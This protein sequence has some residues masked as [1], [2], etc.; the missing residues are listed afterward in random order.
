[1]AASRAIGRHRSLVGA[2]IDAAP[3]IRRA[4]ARSL[5][6]VREHIVSVLAF[7]SADY[8]TFRLNA[9][10]GWIVLG[11]SAVVFDWLARG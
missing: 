2:L 9:Y 3:G 11:V 7:T 4:A 10:A 1:V 5:P 6:F 8:G